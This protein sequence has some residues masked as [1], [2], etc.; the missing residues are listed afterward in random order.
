VGLFEG[1]ERR[2]AVLEIVETIHSPLVT[3]PRYAVT[4]Q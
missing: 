4:K 3:Y 2:Q 1:I